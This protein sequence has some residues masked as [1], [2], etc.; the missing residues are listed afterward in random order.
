MHTQM[1]FAVHSSNAYIFS[2]L[3]LRHNDW[4]YRSRIAWK[5][6]VSLVSPLCQL[7]YQN[8]SWYNNVLILSNK[9][10][11][12]CILQI[13]SSYLSALPFLSYSIYSIIPVGSGAM[14]WFALKNY[15][16]FR[17][18]TALKLLLIRVRQFI[19]L[20]NSPLKFNVYFRRLSRWITLCLNAIDI[21]VALIITIIKFYHFV[22]FL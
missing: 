12:P 10:C 21:S 22:I 18:L 5:E 7:Y 11:D 4:I 17:S 15:G 1:L 9:N 8:N 19:A 13:I 16:N 20:D 6:L 2:V 14:Y 3:L